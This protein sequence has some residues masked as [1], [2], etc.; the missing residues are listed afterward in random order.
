MRQMKAIRRLKWWIGLLILT[1]LAAALAPAGEKEFPD[2]EIVNAV[3]AVLDA[4]QAAWNRGDI[5]AFM[6]G[7]AHSNE[8]VFVSGDKVTRGWETVLRNYQDKYSDRARMGTLTFN[9]LEVMPLSN[10]SAVVL[11]RWELKRANDSPHGRFTLIFRKLTEGWR[12]VQD[13][14]S[15]APTP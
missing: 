7:Y 11:G 8:T 5:P 2:P 12:I 1:C 9:D 6:D 14:T 13:H 10:E 3:R 4:Q 15:A